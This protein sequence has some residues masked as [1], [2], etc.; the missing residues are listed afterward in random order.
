MKIFL[1]ALVLKL[2]LFGM[3]VSAHAQPRLSLDS[4][5]VQAGEQA[6]LR[7]SLSNGAD[8][9]AGVNAQFVLPEGVRLA[10]VTRGPLLSSAFFLELNPAT[11]TVIAYASSDVFNAADGVL[12]HLDLH[13]DAEMATGTYPIAFREPTG[14]FINVWYALSNATGSISRSL[15]ATGGSLTVGP[16]PA[17]VSISASVGSGGGGTVSGG[18]DSVAYNSLV[19]LTAIPNRGWVFRHWTENGEVVSGAR[20]T[21]TF[22]ATSNRNL[23]AHFMEAKSLPGVLMLLL[24]DE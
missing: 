9:Y 16:P 21:Y 10:S 20:A 4:A 17:P 1:S 24:D 8:Q 13:V 5:N 7:L 11:A 6:T 3:L 2:F 15:S 14:A 19:T 18:G 23:I 22:P 12:L